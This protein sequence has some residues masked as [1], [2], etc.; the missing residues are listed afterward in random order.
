MR[1]LASGMGSRN[2]GLDWEALKD[3]LDK[4]I[5]DQKRKLGTINILVAGQ[6]GAGKSTLVNAVFGE[7]FAKT[8]R[9][10]PVTKKATWYARDG[11]PLRM[12]D[13]RGLEAASYQETL[14]D[15]KKAILAGRGSPVANEQIHIAWICVQEGG[16][17]VQEADFALARLLMSENI[18]VIVVVTKHG[19]DPDFADEVPDLFRSENVPIEAVIPVRA[20]PIMGQQEVGLAELVRGTFRILPKAVQGA[21]SAAQQ[22]DLDMKIS[23]SWTC[24]HTAAT[25]AATAAAI[26]LPFADAIALV[27]IQIGMVVAISLRFGI[28]PDRE[29]LLPLAGCIIGCLA[30]TT[31]GRWVVGQLLKLVPGFGIVLNATVATALTEAFGGAYIHFLERFYRL[32]GRPPSVAEIETKF[33]DFWKGAERRV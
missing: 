1:V 12:L 2:N 4:A 20:K 5:L 30:T 8:A 14:D 25:A 32:N 18:P 16:G 31:A 6:T 26:P 19:M 22:I 33:P 3:L 23:S 15:L 13:T 28:E 11:H 21:F 17:R 29:Q 27:P 7:E 24:V 9:G 10:K